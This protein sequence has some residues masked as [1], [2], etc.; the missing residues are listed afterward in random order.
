MSGSGSCLPVF[1]DLE[2]N[3][4]FSKY[5]TLGVNSARGR[6]SGNIPSLLLLHQSVDT[7]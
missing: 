2:M 3:R 4:Y 7:V 5:G 6:K 1:V